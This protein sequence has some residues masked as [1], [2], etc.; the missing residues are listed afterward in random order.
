MTTR[1]SIE[2]DPS[3]S[4]AATNAEWRELYES[5]LTP[6]YGS[7]RL[8]LV[9]GE[10]SRVWDAEGREY[11]D[12]LT[13]L[14]VNNLGHC[15]PRVTKAIR[16]QAGTLVHCS[17]LYYIPVQIELARLLTANCFADRMFFCNSGAEANEAAIKIA[18]RWTRENR[19]P[20]VNHVIS[21]KRSFHG[22]SIT[23][24]SATGQ[25]KIWKDFYPLARGFYF[26]T[27]NDLDSI[28]RL[29]NKHTCAVIVEPVQGE[30]GV[31]PATG[32]FLTGL[33]KLCT[34]RGILLIF[35]E[36]QCGLGRVGSLFAHQRYGVEPDVMTLAK[37]LG[38]GLAMGAMLTTE[39][40]ASA[41]G[42]GAHAST[43]GGNALTSAAGL[44]YLQELI[45]GDYAGQAA[46]SGEYVFGRLRGELGDCDNVVDIR[47]LGLMIGIELKAGGPETVLAC[48]EKGLLI[49]CTAG[50]TVRLLP[51][52]NVSRQDLDTALDILIPEI[53]SAGR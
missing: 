31:W 29:M 30:G 19:G 13:G 21:M 11:L 23:T 4:E 15:H 51:P 17:N 28:E 37:S 52:L 39:R 12:F 49:N 3:V 16:E 44:A 40:I 6:N 18:R 35:D 53:K 25:D 34:D 26:A 41:F 8:A 46:E 14:S 38:G 10:G 20:N 43:M 5:A 2:N 32:E 7:R 1:P 22:R 45:E 24:L 36:V 50:Q 33:R 42:I 27:L 48:E 47:G 9:R